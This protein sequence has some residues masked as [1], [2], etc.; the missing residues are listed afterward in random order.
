MFS[1]YEA[2]CRV[3]W[4]DTEQCMANKL[5]HDSEK[6]YPIMGKGY[7][8]NNGSPPDR[9]ALSNTAKDCCKN[10]FSSNKKSC[11]DK[12]KKR[13]YPDYDDNHCKNDG[14]EPQGILM[15]KTYT[16]CCD[17][18]MSSR[19]TQC[20]LDSES[21]EINQPS[22]TASPS[23]KPSK[24]PTQKPVQTTTT[25]STS[26]A[27]TDSCQNVSTKKRCN[28][29]DSCNWIDGICSSSHSL[30]TTARPSLRPSH[31]L[32]IINECERQTNKRKCAQFDICRWDDTFDNCVS[33]VAPIAS[34]CK[35]LKNKRQCRDDTSCSWNVTFE[36][37]IEASLVAATTT[38][39]TT[40][41][42]TI[43]T[44]SPTTKV[45]ALKHFYDY[46]DIFCKNQHLSLHCYSPQEDHVLSQPP[47]L[48]LQKQ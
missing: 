35:T 16:K 48:Q 12:S 22:L 4:M 7:C 23:K 40:T 30:V 28:N 20:V 17:R 39:T 15:S 14:N 25:T 5:I 29:Y 11:E 8:L 9:V 38:T 21:F 3:N 24:K 19:R 46:T 42:T 6:W 13:W 45:S 43:T 18:F 37:C 36:I 10:F 1:T 27:S 33:L 2:C 41:T 32:S 44:I 31:I 26:A 47:S 34:G